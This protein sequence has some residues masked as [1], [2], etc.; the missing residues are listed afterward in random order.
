MET[1]KIKVSVDSFKEIWICTYHME[2]SVNDSSYLWHPMGEFSGES[3][4]RNHHQFSKLPTYRRY[5]LSWFPIADISSE[6]PESNPDDL[7]C[8]PRAAA[9]VLLGHLIRLSQHDVTSALGQPALLWGGKVS[10]ENENVFHCLPAPFISIKK[11]AVIS[12]VGYFSFHFHSVLS[13][14]LNL[15]LQ[16]LIQCFLADFW[17]NVLRIHY[18]FWP[19]VMLWT[20]GLEQLNLSNFFCVHCFKVWI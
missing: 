19:L 9:Y 8:L 1:L 15:I 12:F 18:S 7:I 10:K 14:F 4:K 11:S 5:N 3:P 20:F 17:V 13:T 6:D 16:L 2:A